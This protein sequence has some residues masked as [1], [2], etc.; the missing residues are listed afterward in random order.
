MV[1]LRWEFLKRDWKGGK[2]VDVGG[3]G[4]VELKPISNT[5]AKPVIEEIQDV[6]KALKKERT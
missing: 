1:K 4:E 5:E 6:L 3:S 2:P